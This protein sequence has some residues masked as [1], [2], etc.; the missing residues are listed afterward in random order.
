MTETREAT[1]E[2]IQRIVEDYAAAA[3][4]AI[5][6]G[7]DGV[8]VKIG[9]DGLLHAFASPFRPAQVRLSGSQATVLKKPASAKR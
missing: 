5:R 7:F 4:N 1:S 9:H 6:A 8:E 2:D 3:R